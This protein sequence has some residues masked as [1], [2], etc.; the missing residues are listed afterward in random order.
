V[1][2]CS[3][4]PGRSTASGV[5]LGLAALVCASQPSATPA[6]GQEVSAQARTAYFHAV[7]D[8]FGVPVQEV[9]ILGEWDLV[10]EEIPVVLFLAKSSGVSPDAVVGLRRGGRSWMDIADRFGLAVSVFHLRF[11]EGVPLGL[12]ERAYGE[13]R[14]RPAREWGQVRLDD[15]EIVALVNIRVVSEQL[16]QPSLGV[17]RAREESGGFVAAYLRLRGG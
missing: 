16:S 14:G 1:V 17:L 8:H 3:A 4:D 15:A 2:K 13:F 9:A 12:L 6:F 7:A 5:I 10:A 11:P